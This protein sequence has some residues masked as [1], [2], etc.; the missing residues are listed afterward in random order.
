VLA[1]VPET[2]ALAVVDH[3]VGLRDLG[4]NVSLPIIVDKNRFFISSGLRAR[5]PRSSHVKE[6]AARLS[7]AR[8]RLGN[9]KH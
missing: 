1:V 9:I 5:A 6:A 3:S 8:H 4:I 7:P 2:W